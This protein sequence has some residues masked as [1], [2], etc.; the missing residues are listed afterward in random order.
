MAGT[1]LSYTETTGHP[2]GTQ[3]P[4]APPVRSIC[5]RLLMMALLVAVEVIVYPLTRDG[6]HS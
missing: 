4:G 5:T 3:I 2:H 1:G 6:G